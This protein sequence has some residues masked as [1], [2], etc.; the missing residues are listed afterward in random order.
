MAGVYPEL[1]EHAEATDM[2]LAAEEEGFGRT[3][4]QGMS[5]L[6]EHIERARSEGS[7]TISA[8][9]VFRLHDTFGFPYEM[10][11]ELLSEEGL[12]I[13]GTFEELMERQRERG[14]AGA[15]GGASAGDGSSSREVA[16]TFAGQSGFSTR[17]T[18]YET[19]R[20]QTTVG[21]LQSFGGGERYLV[22][23]AESPFYAPGGGQ[24][25]DVGVIEC[26]EGDCRAR[27]EDV[28]RIGDDQALA[29]TV[30]EG[31]LHEGESV[32]AQVDRRSR[33]ATECNHTATHLLQAALRE[34]LGGH[35]RQ[36]GSYVGPDKLRFD[37]SHGQ[38]VSRQELADIED[39]VNEWISYNDPVRSITTTLDEARS[40]GAMALF[41]EKYGEIVRMVEVGG[42][43]Y[44]RELCGGT[45]VRST[46][47]IGPFRIISETSSSANVR[48]IEAVTGPAAVELLREHDSLLGE[49]AAQLRT[50][51]QDAP[52]AVRTLQ[53]E[54]KRLEKALKS[55]GQGAAEGGGP[56]P[57]ALAGQAIE[58]G[59]ARVLAVAVGSL[60]AKALLDLLDRVKG[61]LGAAAILLG[62][63]SEGRV[64]LIVSVA[65][66]LVARGVKAGAIVKSA[67][68]VV[69]GGGGGRDTMAQAGGRDPERLDEAIATGLA[70]IESALV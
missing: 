10:T 70:A 27:V 34:R 13:E 58:V 66:E 45:H 63:S 6:R 59:G 29:V 25:A 30:E 37:F 53:E 14:R 31:K 18:G 39:R 16:G 41:G 26:A 24:V 52:G 62:S 38:A 47:E 54:R 17:F 20:Q 32:L 65:P 4:A 1:H 46:A 21:A 40:L 44:S 67:A 5:Q 56:D 64:H 68:E 35:I 15:R 22:K 43:D 33:H 55:G 48:R 19:E 49:I 42:G 2:W 61:K 50:R 51:P 23:L 3:L 60:E 11:S 36:A 8:E 57:S 7:E 12:Q 28:F 69:G 9:D